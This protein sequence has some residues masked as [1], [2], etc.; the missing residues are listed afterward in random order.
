M[1]TLNPRPF[2]F[3]ALS[4]IL[5][6]LSAMADEDKVSEPSAEYLAVSENFVDS[7]NY[8][9]SETIH[10]DID[11]EAIIDTALDGL[12]EG[13][14][15]RRGFK[16][17]FLQSQ[18]DFG[19]MFLANFPA[20]STAKLIRWRKFGKG[21]NALVRID[22]DS[23]LNYLDLFIR[24][25]KA[26]KLKI[27][28]M[29]QLHAGEP[30]TTSIRNL[31]AFATPNQSVTKMLLGQEK[32][33]GKNANLLVDLLNDARS[34]DYDAFTKKYMKAN[35][36]V[37]S[38]KSACLAAYQIGTLDM[39]GELYPKALKDLKQF[40]GNEPG[41]ALMML[42]VYFAE[43]DYDSVLKCLNQIEKYS[44]GVPDAAL[45]TL[46]TNT[47]MVMKDYDG[48]IK[49]AQNAIAIEPDYSDAYFSLGESQIAGGKF[50]D[51]VA[52]LKIIG[53]KYFVTFDDYEFEED[54][55]YAKFVESDAYKRWAKENE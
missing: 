37:R 27:V 11:L 35:D 34:G 26:G 21:Y 33:L 38:Q 16:V 31:A 9:N 23:G 44:G 17:G 51:A 39:E 32:G 55:S 12:P 46:E 53:D 50:D 30:Y 28:D 8:G 45:L 15:F 2:L 4:I 7:F 1:N 42:D 48:A 20:D 14:G 19:E 52:T 13:D 5:G 40:F 24:P 22:G 41:M 36:T 25:N 3:L 43:E 18:E 47:R 29:Y 49:S 54:P 10:E 6:Q